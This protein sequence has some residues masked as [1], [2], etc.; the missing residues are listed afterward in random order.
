M[1]EC[2]IQKPEAESQQI[3]RQ[4][5]S[6][7]YNTPLRDKVVYSVS[8]S[9]DGRVVMQGAG[10]PVA[11]GPQARAPHYYGAGA[12]FDG[13]LSLLAWCGTRGMGR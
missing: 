4:A 11:R 12:R 1:R 5:Y 8:I 7:A 13:A 3:V 9:P 10:R 2:Q 6:H